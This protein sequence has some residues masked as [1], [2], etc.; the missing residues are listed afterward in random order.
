MINLF[1]VYLENKI[2]LSFKSFVFL[3]S[4]VSIDGEKCG[5]CIAKANVKEMKNTNT[6][7]KNIRI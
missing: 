2:K 4:F 6:T 1:G 3:L 5:Y 7:S